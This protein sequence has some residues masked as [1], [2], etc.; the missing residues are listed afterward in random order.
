MNLRLGRMAQL[1]APGYSWCLQC[2][3]PWRFVKGHTTKYTQSNGCFPL[4]EKCWAELTPEQRLPFYRA[5]II[6]WARQDCCNG[7]EFDK[8]W[9][10]IREAVLAGL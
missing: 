3:T 1:F 4:C 5:L 10:D 8:T 7:E 9:H 6:E 2:K